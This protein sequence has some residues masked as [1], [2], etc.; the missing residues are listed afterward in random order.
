MQNL[1]DSKNYSYLMTVL[2]SLL[3]V[4][5]A[6]NLSAQESGPAGHWKLQGDLLDNSG[7]TN[8]ARNHVVNPD[9]RAF[10]LAV[11]QGRL[12]S[13]TFPSG[14]VRSFEAGK[15]VSFDKELKSGWR[16]IAAVKQG[17]R[18]KLFIDSKLVAESGEFDAQ[19]FDLT[20]QATLQ[21]GFG[22][23][24]YFKGKISEVRLY[25]RALTEPEVRA[26]LQNK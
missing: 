20:N 14:H 7:N 26:S 11:F 25:K 6:T 22:Q 23:Y 8:T 18:L 9:A 10:S 2:S 21:I 24:D 16:H 15:V 4:R 13:G 3:L 1:R 12:F 17:G 5:L 19:D